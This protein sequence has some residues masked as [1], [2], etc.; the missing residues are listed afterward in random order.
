MDRD[1]PAYKGQADYTRP[2]L[3]AYDRVVLGFVA[4]FVW[5]CPTSEL[6]E[7]YRRHIRNRHLD[8]GPGTGYFIE[9]SGLPAASSVTLVDPNANVLDH[10]SRRLAQYRV[11]QVQADVLKPLPVNGPFDSAALHLVLHCL[12]GP[13]DRKAVAVANVAAV[14]APTGTL[15]GASVLGM[16]GPQT[17]L[18]R[19]VLRAF[20]RQG[21]FDNLGDTEEG[22]RDI[23]AASFEQVVL[24]TVG[25]VAVFAATNPRPAGSIA[26]LSETRPGGLGQPR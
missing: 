25:A 7:R 11:I 22:L 16:S 21:G 14:L 4:W 20:N 15:F 9:A 19:L 13:Q 18:S 12:P 5:R 2:V 1:D 26:G 17:W 6:V 24:E 10:A 8:V 23:L 3:K